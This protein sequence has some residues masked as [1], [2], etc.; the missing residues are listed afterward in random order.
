MDSSSRR[1]TAA[2]N[3]TTGKYLLINTSKLSNDSTDKP[4][5]ITESPSPKAYDLNDSNWMER[6]T[7][8]LR[9]LSTDDCVLRKI[10]TSF[11]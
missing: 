1:R 4:A 2:K 5:Q 6:E 3:S 8:I 9:K 10:K 11:S 7:E